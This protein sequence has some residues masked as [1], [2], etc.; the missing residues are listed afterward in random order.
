LRAPARVNTRRPTTV[1][2]PQRNG[3]DA[4]PYTGQHP[5]SLLIDR[6]IDRAGAQIRLFMSE[7]AAK[8][9]DLFREWDLDGDGRVTK[10][11]FR[12]AAPKI[13]LD[14]PVEQIDEL[15]DSFDPSG[16]GEIEY[17]ELKKALAR[18]PSLK[19][20]GKAVGSAAALGGRG[21]ATR[22]PSNG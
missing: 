22:K 11:E 16:D 12:K 21:S 17:S 13:G 4:P 8:I 19:D 9:I 15:F 20:K 6:V 18:S 5:S 2:I 10:A 14:V 1:T 3:G 7:H